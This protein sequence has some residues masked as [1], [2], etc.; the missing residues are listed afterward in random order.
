MYC[1]LLAEEIDRLKGK[2]ART[3]EPETAVDLKIPAFIPEQYLP[4]EQERL[5]YY[6]KFLNA[7]ASGLKSILAEIEDL[8]GPAPQPLKNT[9]R[10]IETRKKCA[11][12]GIRLVN[13]T[14]Q[15]IEIFFGQGAVIP[16]S[17]VTAWNERF[18]DNIVFLPSKLGDGFR[19]NGIFEDPLSLLE[20]VLSFK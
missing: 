14:E 13:Q 5:N 6:K 9:A 11:S 7:D 2:T 12:M 3:M 17:A 1:E 10:L 18:K 15:G 16:P 8:C 19:I 20:S 4:D